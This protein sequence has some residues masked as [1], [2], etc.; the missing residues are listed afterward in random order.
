VDLTEGEV[1]FVELVI[2]A[3]DFVVEVVWVDSVDV[4]AVV[5]VDVVGVDNVV[6]CK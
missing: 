1:D 6:V 2:V 5:E 3:V 4:D